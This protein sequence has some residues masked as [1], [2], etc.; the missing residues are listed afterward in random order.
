MMSMASTY[1]GTDVSSNMGWVRRELAV[2]RGALAFPPSTYGLSSNVMA[3]IT[4]NC[5]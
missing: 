2:S 1:Y 3:L 5:G 4:S